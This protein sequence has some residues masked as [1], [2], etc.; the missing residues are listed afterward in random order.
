[1]YV[2]PSK[3]SPPPNSKLL[4]CP[5]FFYGKNSDLIALYDKYKVETVLNDTTGIICINDGWSTHALNYKGEEVS[6]RKS[7][8]PDNNACFDY[9]FFSIFILYNRDLI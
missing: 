2:S 4:P 7:Q 3:N 6:R 8:H 9:V 1:M 5:G